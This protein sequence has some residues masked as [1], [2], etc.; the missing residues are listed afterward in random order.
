[1]SCALLSFVSAP[2][3]VRKMLVVDTMLET[4]TLHGSE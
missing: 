4:M 1:M 3:E 2:F